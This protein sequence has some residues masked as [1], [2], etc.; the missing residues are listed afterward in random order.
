M[1]EEIIRESYIVSIKPLTPIHVWSGIDHVYG[2]DLVDYNNKICFIDLDKII[3]DMTTGIVDILRKEGDPLVKWNRVIRKYGERILGECIEYGNMSKI[4]I[5]SK[6]KAINSHIIPGST[7]KGYIRTALLYYKLSALNPNILNKVLSQISTS[8]TNP[9]NVSIGIEAYAF[10]KP[11]PIK[12]KGFI[13]LLQLVEVSDP[14]EK[15]VL[16]KLMKFLVMEPV[17]NRLQKVAENNVIAFFDGIVKHRLTIRNPPVVQL[18]R[19]H[20][21]VSEHDDILAKFGEIKDVDLIDALG[22]FGCFIV[23]SELDRLSEIVK[24]IDELKDYYHRLTQWR[25]SY[26][27]GVGK[28]VIGRIGFM[29]GHQAKTIL[30]LIKSVDQQL[31]NQIIG[32]LS[33]LFNHVWDSRTLKL[34][35]INN[36]LLGTGWCEICLERLSMK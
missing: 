13:D 8:L 28:C 9:K 10:R 27:E 4:S 34:T 2:V 15:N 17:S 23:R 18:D 5:G 24:R 3:G 32:Y 6:V 30:P 35:L 1:G 26:C 29:T 7:L 22:S 20:N 11:R 33:K 36:S 14:L 21:K 16:L 25:R 31:Y 12:A 19:I